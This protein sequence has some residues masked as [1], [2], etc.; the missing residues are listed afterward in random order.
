MSGFTKGR[1]PCV[2]RLGE[3][4]QCRIG[5]RNQTCDLS[6]FPQ[7]CCV[8]TWCVTLDV[9]WNVFKSDKPSAAVEKCVWRKAERYRG[10]VW[11]E[12]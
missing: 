3:C 4:V 12:F 5:V 10:V 2:Q 6:V 7:W 9:V 11:I 8:L 1:W